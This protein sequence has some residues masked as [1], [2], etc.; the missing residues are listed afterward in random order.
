M[1]LQKTIYNRRLLLLAAA[2]AAMLILLPA[3]AALRQA[4]DVALAQSGGH[5]PPTWYTVERGTASGGG[6]HLTSLSWRVNGTA[7][8]EGYRLLGP[9][10]PASSENGCC[11]IYLPCV[12]RSYQ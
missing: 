11:C 8:G 2:L 10:A 6:Y 12:L 5:D 3:S 7:G 9:A 1:N 4:Q